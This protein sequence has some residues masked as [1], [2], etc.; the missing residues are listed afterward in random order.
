MPVGSNWAGDDHPTVA[1]FRDEGLSVHRQVT[2]EEA[3]SKGWY[4]RP[5]PRAQLEPDTRKCACHGREMFAPLQ[6][7]DAER[8]IRHPLSPQVL[9]GEDGF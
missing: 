3:A 7:T 2:A 5:G 4:Y 9:L 6:L 8:R 1:I